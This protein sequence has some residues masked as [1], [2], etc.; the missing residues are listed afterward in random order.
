M[1]DFK[2]L[3]KRLEEN[4]ELQESFN[5][6][7]TRRWAADLRAAA[8]LARERA[9]A[10]KPVGYMRPDELAQAK[11]APR[12]CRVHPA[13]DRQAD[14]VPV[15]TYPPAAQPAIPEGWQL[16]PAEP[17][18]DMNNAGLSAVNQHGKRSVW[19]TYQ[20]MLAAAPQ[21]AAQPQSD[22]RPCTCH[23]DDDPPTPCVKKYALS[24]CKA[25]AQPQSE[26]K[27]ENKVLRGALKHAEAA[28]ADIEAADRDLAW[29]ERRAAHA[30]TLVRDAL[31]AKDER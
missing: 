28:L 27:I 12:M 14:M 1:T 25:A 16:V 30:L 21:P 31:A 7:D 22:N 20:A 23:P 15:F 5:V 4:A 8:Q 6:V 29:C 19:L 26:P 18:Q 9:E 2:A 11:D 3:A 10:P 13:K 17:T 24:E